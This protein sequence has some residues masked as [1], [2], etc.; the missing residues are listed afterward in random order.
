MRRTCLYFG[1]PERGFLARSGIFL[2][3][4]Q[5]CVPKVVL[6]KL[7]RVYT[8]QRLAGS[9]GLSHDILVVRIL[10]VPRH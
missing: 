1:V 7:T 6:S 3:E 2:L 9:Q 10:L 5:K 8:V 4:N